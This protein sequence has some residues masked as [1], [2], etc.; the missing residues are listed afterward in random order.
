MV[1]QSLARI[2]R[3]AGLVLFWFLLPAFFLLTCLNFLGFSMYIV[4]SGSMEPAIRTG[5][6]ILTGPFAFSGL[7]DGDVITFR[8][9]EGNVAVTHRIVMID[10]QAKRIRTKGDANADPD[11]ALVREDQIL[12]KVYMDLSLFSPLFRFLASREGKIALVG[13]ALLCLLAGQADL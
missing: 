12:G 1:R 6:T 7:K 8:L 10:Y 13:F 5:S 2:R 11:A 9:G 4:T 3:R